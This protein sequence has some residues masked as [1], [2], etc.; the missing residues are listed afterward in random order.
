MVKRKETKLYIATLGH[1]NGDEEIKIVIETVII[2]D[3]SFLYSLSSYLLKFYSMLPVF[4]AIHPK[5]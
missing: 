5:L 3:F 1:G 4:F 2:F